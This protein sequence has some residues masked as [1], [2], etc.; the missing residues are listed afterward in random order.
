MNNIVFIEGVS[1][2]GKTTTTTLLRDKLQGMGYDAECCLEGAGDNPLDPFGGTYP[3]KIP[4][5]EFSDTY[6]K[7]WRDFAES[8]FKKDSML[9]LDGTLLHHQINDLIREYGAS[10]EIITSYLSNL[11]QLIQRFSPTIFYLSSGNVGQRLAQARKSRGAS[12]PTEEK[13]AFWEN[14]KRVALY[15]LDRLPIESRILNVD[16]GWDA[17]LET[18]TEHL[19]SNSG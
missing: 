10:D 12:I 7:C 16:G 1:G 17:I 5:E 19:A 9:I 8:Q 14:R 11:L 4:L 3:P 2:V 6:L 15:V 18:M 13:I